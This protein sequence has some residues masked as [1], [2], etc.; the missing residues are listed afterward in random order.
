MKNC[1]QLWREARFQ[2]KMYKAPQ[3]RI[4]FRSCD[5]EKVDAVVARSTFGSQ[6]VQN[7]PCTDHF[8]KLT[9]R[10][11]ARHCSAKHISKSKLQKTDGFGHFWKLR[12]RKSASG[13]GAKHIS[14]QKCKKLT[15]SEHF[16]TF[17]CRFAWQAQGIVHLVKSKQNVR[18]L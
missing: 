16:W 14:S 17:R 2:V 12:R 5:I 6:N 4:T 1:T 13:C 18:V 10:K 11:S 15:G 9:C 3:L 7:T 8:W